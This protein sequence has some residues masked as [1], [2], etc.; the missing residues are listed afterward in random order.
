MIRRN[1]A[2]RRGAVM[3]EAAIVLPVML[4]LFLMI[5]VGGV[6]VLRYQQTV[7]LSCEAARWASVRGAQWQSATGQTSPTQQQIFDNAVAPM[8]SGMDQ[9]NISIQVYVVNQTTG[10]AVAW[11]SSNKSPFSLTSSNAP[12]ATHVRVTIT[13]PWSPGFLLGTINLTSTCEIPMSF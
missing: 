13:Y 8:A 4:F 2:H 12:V 11:D 9:N 10:T 1:A 7:T 3:L 5:I 6:G